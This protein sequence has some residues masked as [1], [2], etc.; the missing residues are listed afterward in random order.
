MLYAVHLQTVR[1]Q[2]TALRKRLLA[3]ITLVGSNAGVRS[4][5]P[6]QI[7]RVVESL[8]AERAQ[9]AF[10]VRMAFH[11]AIEQSLERKRFRADDAGEFVWIVVGNGLGRFFVRRRVVAA[12]ASGAASEHVV[13]GEG[14]LEAVAAVDEFELDFGGEAQLFFF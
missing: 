14:I 1:L 2:R 13:E 4:R 5:V 12:V 10:D 9:I 8:A 7:E 6:L 3:Q 11:V